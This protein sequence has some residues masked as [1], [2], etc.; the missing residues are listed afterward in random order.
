MEP[1]IQ[2]FTQSFTQSVAHDLRELAHA[3]QQEESPLREL[4]PPG[5]HWEWHLPLGFVSLAA[6]GTLLVAAGGLQS[7]V[8]EQQHGVRKVRTHMHKKKI[9]V[10]PRPPL[11]S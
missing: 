5:Y 3:T 8:Q 10:T 6:A 9:H 11:H 7:R 2:S 4:D 1:L